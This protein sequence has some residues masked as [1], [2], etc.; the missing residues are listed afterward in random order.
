M[1][2][3]GATFALC[4]VLA[5]PALA[6]D[7]TQWGTS[8]DWVILQDPDHDNACLGQASFSDGSLLRMGFEDK[9]KKGFLATVNPAWKDFKLDHKYPV[10]YLLDDDL[11][12]TEARG[13]EVNGMR[14]AR[15]RFEDIDLIV[16]L[17]TKN[18]LTFMSEGVEMVK[19]D[20][21]GS[22]DAMKQVIACQAAQG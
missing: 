21:K 1:K 10:T 9:G 4:F 8:G 15:I 3:F 2:T 20:L 13:V 11:F 6:L 14:G 7:L 22:D 19:I 18:T 16:D 12:E 17:A 5:A